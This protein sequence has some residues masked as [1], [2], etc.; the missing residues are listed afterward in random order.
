MNQRNKI[1]PLIFLLSI[2]C[3]LFSKGTYI[4]KSFNATVLLGHD[5]NPLRLS[6]N[7]I[8]EL[9]ERPYLLGD[10]S[11]VYSRFLGISGKFSF[12]SNK[13]ILARLFKRKTNFNLGYTYKHFTQNK[14]KNSTY[15]SF[16]INQ[17]LGNYRYL[18]INYSLMPGYYLREYEDLDYILATNDI[19]NVSR[20]YACTFDIEKLH[21]IYQIPLSLKKNKVKIGGFYERQIFDPYFTEFDLNIAGQTLEFSFS[22]DDNY[23]SKKR[24]INFLYE[25]HI[26]DNST[27]LS[28]LVSNLYMNRDY[29]QHRYKFN[30]K[31]NIN[32]SQSIGFIV[33]IYKRNNTSK[34]EVD[35][36]HYKRK[37]TDKTVSVWYKK[38]RY[39][40]MLSKR[41]R[42]SRSPFEWVEELKTFDRYIITLT[43]T[44]AKR[45]FN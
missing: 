43:T 36:L 25:K 26:A 38:N 11:E 28:K 42:L 31:Q 35:E 45:N 44:L 4:A 37:H 24:T 34:I 23:F 41:R 40:I 14:E 32:N 18:H 2:S 9:S 27:F 33:D 8:E 15:I 10:A 5:S 17:Q 1:K 3:V 12:Y 16:K 30:F 39:K 22:N 13:A 20:Y 7:E 29:K 19:D 21:I 6:K